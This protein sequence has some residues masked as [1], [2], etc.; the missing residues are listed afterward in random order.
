M[1]SFDPDRTDTD[2]TERAE[3]SATAVGTCKSIAERWG[4]D[5]RQTARLMGMPHDDWRRALIA[6]PTLD[7]EQ[8]AR[9]SLI[10]GLYRELHALFAH[11]V[12]DR[13]PMAPNPG[14]PFNGRSPVAT[15]LD[16][17]LEAMWATRLVVA[18][19]DRR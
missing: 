1:A 16:G 13:W 8:F 9:A 12:A 4:L 6:A 2:A 3:L 10:L 11:D 17:G 18:A 14:D 19:I 7:D 5:Q 15:M